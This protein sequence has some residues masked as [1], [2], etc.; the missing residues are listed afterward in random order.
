[1]VDLGNSEDFLVSNLISEIFTLETKIGSTG[2]IDIFKAYDR[3]RNRGITVLISRDKFD[4]KDPKLQLFVRRMGKLTRVN[5]GLANI[6]S[7]GLDPSGVLF[8]IT[9]SV[10]GH[11]I[12]RG[13][14]DQNEAERRWSRCVQIVSEMHGLGIPVGDI[15]DESFWV[16]RGGDITLVGLIGTVA[17][18][19]EQGA[20]EAMKE[21]AFHI[22]QL[23]ADLFLIA[24]HSNSLCETDP[25]WVEKLSPS[26]ARWTKETLEKGASSIPSRRYPN[27]IK[28]LEDLNH[29]KAK[30]LDEESQVQPRT[31]SSVSPKQQASGV[32]V[33]GNSDAG[34]DKNKDEVK[35][36]NDNK[37]KIILVV[38]LGLLLFLVGIIGLILYLQ[39]KSPDPSP[40]AQEY[41]L[42]SN[43]ADERMRG[44][45]DVL[46]SD[47]AELNEKRAKFMQ[48]EESDDPLAHSLLVEAAISTNSTKERLLAE[49]S[50][51]KRAERLG[52][53]YPLTV[54]RIWIDGTNPMSLPPEYPIILK[55]IDGTAPNS[56]RAELLE[57]TYAINKELALRLLTGFILDAKESTKEYE[58]SARTMV[59]DY[60]QKPVPEYVSALA[61]LSIAPSCYYAYINEFN[62]KFETFSPQE[63]N[64]LVTTE[65]ARDK[66]PE[67]VLVNVAVQ[68]SAFGPAGDVLLRP[69]SLEDPLP[70][71]MLGVISRLLQGQVYL[72]D[73]EQLGAWLHPEAVSILGGILLIPDLSDQLMSETIEYVA[74]KESSRTNVV[75]FIQWLQRYKWDTRAEWGPLLGLM[76]STAPKEHEFLKKVTSVLNKLNDNDQ[77]FSILLGSENESFIKF[78]LDE[79][80]QKIPGNAMVSLLSSDNP[81]MRIYAIKSLAI[82]N[83][84]SV[85]QL[86]RASYEAE[87]DPEVRK[88]YE[89]ELWI[90]KQ[91][92]KDR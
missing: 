68:K 37:R 46:N 23:G 56:V 67:K 70:E 27:V 44:A 13:N 58:Q 74:G 19:S 84:T 31:S 9:D 1:M 59:S 85:L 86:V 33:F 79:F 25:S 78:I 16:T 21:D 89:D 43:A 32:S 91:S 28:L 39:F 66:F 11:S 4:P 62:K 18:W 50:L 24:S 53:K 77:L 42:L 29:T 6:Y 7:I 47:D 5:G 48:L 87:K 69:L 2:V 15:T 57:R 72:G 65:L 90:I 30:I 55:S 22:S 92:S 80:K 52:V 73:I 36:E 12:L 14:I 41:N 20:S 76:T 63:L 35:A 54:V 8:C 88:A 17:S 40:E 34:T 26:V 75:S 3:E 38:V 10:D 81:A 71:G 82:V 45:M 51:L 61:S 83:D 49:S 60:L 64:W